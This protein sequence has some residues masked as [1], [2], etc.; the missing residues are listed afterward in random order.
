MVRYL[1]EL[2]SGQYLMMKVVIILYTI[3]GRM[4]GVKSYTSLGFSLRR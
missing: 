2:K 3:G 4:G 1:P